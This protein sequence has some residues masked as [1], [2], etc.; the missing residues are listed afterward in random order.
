MT[1]PIFTRK[2]KYHI[3]STL[4]VLLMI[5]F[6]VTLFAPMWAIRYALVVLAIYFGIEAVKNYGGDE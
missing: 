4:C 2:E 5:L 6:S 3:A 1:K